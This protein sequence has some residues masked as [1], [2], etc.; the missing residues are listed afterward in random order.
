MTGG[1]QEHSPGPAQAREKE[2]P[3]ARRAGSPAALRELLVR[4]L[5]ERLCLS[6]L[7]SL[8]TL[9]GLPG[10]AGLSPLWPGK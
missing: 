7:P 1:M 2:T 9:P 6:S 4:A 5:E 10:E 8:S 3:P